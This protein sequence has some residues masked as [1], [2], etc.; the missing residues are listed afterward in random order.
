VRH[1]YDLLEKN[2]PHSGRALEVIEGGK[3]ELYYLV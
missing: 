3:K 2:D 1:A